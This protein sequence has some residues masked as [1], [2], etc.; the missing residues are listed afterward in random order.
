M[1][2]IKKSQKGIKGKRQGPR[3][4]LLCNVNKYQKCRGIR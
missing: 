1:Y 4:V 2:E 3:V